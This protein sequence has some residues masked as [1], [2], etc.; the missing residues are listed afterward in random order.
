MV[1]DGKKQNAILLKIM[2][3]KVKMSDKDVFKRFLSYTTMR[4]TLNTDYVHDHNTLELVQLRDK[5]K[6]IQMIATSKQEYFGD[7]LS[8][9][10]Q[11]PDYN[12]LYQNPDLIPRII[13]RLNKII[14]KRNLAER[15]R[16]QKERKEQRRKGK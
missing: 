2:L 5:I 10:F 9:I 3:V 16:K 1:D 8:I 14:G 12:T 13:D 7:F 6:A 4:I 11:H 15:Q